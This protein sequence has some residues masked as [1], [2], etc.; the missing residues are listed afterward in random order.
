METDELRGIADDAG[1]QL[2]RV[3]R[4]WL[5][6]YVRHQVDAQL[7]PGALAR[8]LEELHAEPGD[9]DGVRPLE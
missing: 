5:R 2:Q 3:R 4:S 6:R 1:R 9:P 7:E 8:A